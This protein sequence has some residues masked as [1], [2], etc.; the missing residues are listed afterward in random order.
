M[1]TVRFCGLTL[2]ALVVA[3]LVAACVESEAPPNIPLQSSIRY[4]DR[5]FVVD[6][7]QT[8]PTDDFCTKFGTPSQAD[9]TVIEAVEGF[10]SGQIDLDEPH[11]C[12]IP[13]IP[14]TLTVDRIEVTNDLFQ[15]CVD[16]G[17]CDRPDPSD[18]SASQVCTDEDDFDRCPVVEVPL[19]E[20]TRMCEFIGRRLPTLIEAIA[21][22]QANFVNPDNPQ[23][24]DMAPFIDGTSDEPVSCNDARLNSP[25]CNATRPTPVGSAT[26][27]QGS[28]INDVVNGLDG[29]IFDLTGSQTEWTSDGFP[30]DRLGAAGL[31]WFCI[32][33]LPDEN[34]NPPTCPVIDANAGVTAPCVYGSYQPPG[35]PYGVYPVCI[36][37][38]QAS[39]SGQIGTLAGGGILDQ[40]TNS[41]TVGVFALRTETD[42]EGDSGTQ[43]GYGFRC[44]DDRPSADEMGNLQPFNRVEVDTTF[45]P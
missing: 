38:R 12:F 4:G 19:D 6:F 34:Q 33:P 3:A 11:N 28:A 18:A 22:R 15:L 36:T 13:V 26:D 24:G 2:A 1:S 43:R 16:S 14:K 42:P 10:G 41:R 32:A 30:L 21:I 27:P 37:G 45:V 44:V 35:Q 29:P 17:V 40:L 5:I 7:R 39:S 8:G 31:P 23:P 25:Q 20:A 9:P